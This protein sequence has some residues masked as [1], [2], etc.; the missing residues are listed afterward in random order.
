MYKRFKRDPLYSFNSLL[1]I[2]LE[3]SRISFF[4]TGTHRTEVLT[5]ISVLGTEQPEA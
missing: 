3:H 2:P 1:V 5:W 4:V